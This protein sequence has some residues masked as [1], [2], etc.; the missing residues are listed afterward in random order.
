MRVEP[1]TGNLLD[2]VKESRIVQKFFVELA[3]VCKPSHNTTFLPFVPSKKS[4]MVR[5]R[6]AKTSNAFIAQDS[7]RCGVSQSVFVAFLEGVLDLVKIERH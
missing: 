6:L 4:F 3:H 7:E 5:D 2:L 1:L